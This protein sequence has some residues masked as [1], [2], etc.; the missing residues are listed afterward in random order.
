[1]K[2]IQKEGFEFGFKQDSCTTC[3]GKCCRGK[4]GRIWVDQQ[5]TLQISTFLRINSIDFVR[6]YLDRIGN[7]L[8]IKERITEG[9]FECVFFDVS[10]KNC[11]IYAVRPF[12]CGTYPFWEHFRR[13]GELAIMECPGIVE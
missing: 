8:S 3:D 6:K 11:S 9:S 7:R 12:Q 10:Q 5:N 13:N 4:S 1:M 2:I